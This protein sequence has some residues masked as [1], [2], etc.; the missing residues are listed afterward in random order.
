MKLT[1]MIVN[2]S[3]RPSSRAVRPITTDDDGGHDAATLPV[4]AQDPE[5]VAEEAVDV[6]AQRRP[7]RADDG[8][9]EPLPS[10]SR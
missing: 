8:S 5:R 6:A 1:T 9:S 4:V 7:E 3:G 2:T 10:L